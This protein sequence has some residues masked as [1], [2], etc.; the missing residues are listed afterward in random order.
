MLQSIKIFTGNISHFISSSPHKELT[1]SLINFYEKMGYVFEIKDLLLTLKA[2]IP[3][4]FKT[5]ELILFYESKQTG[6]RR[7]YVKTNIFYEQEAKKMWPF[8]DTIQPSTKEHNLYLAHEIGRPFSKTLIIPL[9]GSELETTA[10]LFIELNQTGQFLKQLT[11]FFEERFFLLH[12][13]FKRVLSNTNFIRISYLWS[14]LFTHWWEPLAILQNFQVIRSNKAFKEVLPVFINPLKQKKLSGLI[15]VENKIYQIHYYPISQFKN[16]K[17]AGILYGQ[18]LTK[19]FHLKEQLFQSKKMMSICNLGKNMA[20]QLNNPLTGIRSMVQILY[21]DPS[22]DDFKEELFEVE[23]AAKRSQKIIESLLS[24]SQTQ[25]EQ[26]LCNLN[27][28]V[29][30]TLPLLKSMT[31]GLLLKTKLCTQPVKVRGDFSI[32]QQVAYNIILN[33]CQALKEDKNN[34]KPYIQI[35]T[36]KQ[37]DK[38]CLKVKDNGPGIAKQNLE[39][40]FQ[41]LWTSKKK[42]Q[43]TGLGLGISRRFVRELGGNLLVS[44]KEK[45]FTCFTVLLPLSYPDTKN[46]HL[47][48]K[49]KNSESKSN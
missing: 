44:S 47:N 18:D 7:A 40:I 33:A 10:L 12:L 14:Q 45:E 48:N 25:E 31:K 30:D 49:K 11:D 34:I 43:G 42:G 41:T 24:F 13:I 27:Q 1:N 37:N 3:K 16:L 6:L 21:Q 5:G 17:E 38:V 23:K 29:E 39:K 8:L 46:I 9:K 36:S 22:L 32:L 26:E 2:Q 4:K 20:H 15:E 28:V 35:S 19:H